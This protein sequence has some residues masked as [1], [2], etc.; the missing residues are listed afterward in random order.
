MRMLEWQSERIAEC[1]MRRPTVLLVA[2]F[3]L[4]WIAEVPRLPARK[5]LEG[6][7]RY[8]REHP[9]TTM[10]QRAMLRPAR[11]DHP[12]N[13]FVARGHAGGGRLHGA[14]HNGQPARDTAPDSGWPVGSFRAVR[15]P[16]TV[17][18]DR[19][20][21]GR[22]A[23][24]AATKRLTILRAWVT[25]THVRWLHGQCHQNDTPNRVARCD[26]KIRMTTLRKAP[27]VCHQT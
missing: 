4:A 13:R 19:P 9:P 27:E 21:Q 7:R 22:R 12:G 18:P 1:T 16:A 24:C 15:R 2:F 5:G 11:G 14:A 25:S 17:P 26:P 20:L 8:L 10:H 23:S 3:L 6:I